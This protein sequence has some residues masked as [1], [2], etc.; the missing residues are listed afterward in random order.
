[1]KGGRVDMG[2]KGMRWMGGL[3]GEEERENF[4]WNV[5]Y[6]RIIIKKKL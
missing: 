3:G 5:I 2:R 6:E 4:S 1:V